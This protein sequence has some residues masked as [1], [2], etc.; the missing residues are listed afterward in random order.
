M[1]DILAI[2]RILADIY[3]LRNMAVTAVDERDQTTLV[4]ELREMKR[5]IATLEAM[6]IQM[7]AS[8]PM[9][10]SELDRIA[11]QHT[12]GGPI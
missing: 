1:K 7:E 10:T 2:R 12:T 8:D 5:K 4:N 6:A 9:P 11:K 3:Y